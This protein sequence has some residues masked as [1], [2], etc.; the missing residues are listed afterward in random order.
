M[1]TDFKITKSKRKEGTEC[2]QIQFVIDNNVCVAFTGS[3][4]LIDQVKSA[5][6]KK[7]MPF[8]GVIVKRDKYY[9]FS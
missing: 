9:S 4:V 2:L 7:C 8:R 3:V 1:V 5:K 6:D